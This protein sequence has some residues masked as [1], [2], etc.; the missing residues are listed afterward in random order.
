MTDPFARFVVL[1]RL[2]LDDP[3]IGVFYGPRFSSLKVRSLLQQ[4]IN[5]SGLNLFLIVTKTPDK[6]EDTIWPQLRKMSELIKDYA[7]RFGFKIYFSIPVMQ[8]VS[9]LILFLAPKEILKAR[10][11]KG[12]SA[13]LSKAQ[14]DF[15][16]MHK[17]ALGITAFEDR[18]YALEENRYESL[19]EVMKDVIGGKVKKKHKDIVLMGSK[20]FVNKIPGKYAETVYAE[21]L[22]KLSI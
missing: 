8:S 14:K 20:L 4:F 2:F 19:R 3:N 15:L 22:K 5:N 6:S 10:L 16:N 17:K 21:L 18:L 9:G 13:F 11:I 1:S 7:E 12:P